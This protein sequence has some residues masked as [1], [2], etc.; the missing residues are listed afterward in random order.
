[1]LT[2]ELDHAFITFQLIIQCVRSHKPDRDRYEGNL[3]VLKIE[4]DAAT[5]SNILF[6]TSVNQFDDIMIIIMSC[7][8][9]SLL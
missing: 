2:H 1:M 3:K 8:Q 6:T 4:L 7:H 9:M 5:F